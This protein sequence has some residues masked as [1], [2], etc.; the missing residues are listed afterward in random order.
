[1]PPSAPAPAARVFDRIRERVPRVIR[2]HV[3]RQLDVRI[4]QNRDRQRVAPALAPVLADTR[5]EWTR[6]GQGTRALSEILGSWLVACVILRTVSAGRQNEFIQLPHGTDVITRVPK[7]IDR[8]AADLPAGSVGR[9]VGSDAESVDVQV[10]GIG[11]V[12][13]RRDEV[14]PFRSGQ[15][16]YAVARD[17]AWKAL[18]GNIVVEATVGSH[19][20]G[21]AEAHSDVDRRG[22][23]VLPFPWSARLGAAQAELTS[24]DGSSTYWEIAKVIAQAVR[25]DPN[26][27]EMLFVPSVR[28]LDPLGQQVLSERD[29]FASARIYASFGQYA[30][31]QLKKLK[32]SLRL[33]DH[34]DVVLGWLRDDA[35]LSLDQ[36]AARLAVE[37]A[38]VGP[39]AQLTA[40]EHIKQLYA[41]LCD[42]GILPEKSFEALRNH[43]REEKHAVDLPRRLRPKNAYNLLRLLLTATHWL[44]AGAPAFEMQ[45]AVREELLRIKRGE[46]ELDAVVARAQALKHDLD[47]AYRTTRLPERPDLARAQRLLLAVREE[48]AQRWLVRAPGAFG[49]DAPSVALPEWNA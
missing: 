46:V 20:W 1:M 45:G 24:V 37:A 8:T 47:E 30:L 16:R 19:A 7:E 38:I 39:D 31:S 25:A 15:L 9:I 43:A 13:Y 35:T 44:R 41:S 36:A 11:V 33:A 12:R 6:A 4:G 32:R 42:Q 34:H 21:L 18:R 27:L 17:A 14:A 49:A 3:Q 5:G 29:A 23:F 48:A 28:A 10:L 40:K 2:D 22:L 26:T